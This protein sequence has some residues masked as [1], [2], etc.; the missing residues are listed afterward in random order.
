VNRRE[1]IVALRNREDE[2][3]E[4]LV[5]V[6]ERLTHFR[7]ESPETGP[8]RAQ[9]P[10]GDADE[11]RA[12][13]RHEAQLMREREHLKRELASI[14]I[15]HG[16]PLLAQVT[17]ATPCPASWEDM[18]GDGNVRFCSQCSKHVYDLSMLTQADAEALILQHEGKM[19]ARVFLRVDGTVM[20][21]DCWVGTRRVGIV[22]VCAVA[23]VMALV[24]AAFAYDAAT[25]ELTSKD[26]PCEARYVEGPNGAMVELRGHAAGQSAICVKPPSQKTEHGQVFRTGGAMI[27][28]HY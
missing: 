1:R 13:L 28:P 12:L 18:R 3:R 6:R 24:G 23:S 8:Y 14:G 19:C 26:D 9:A 25:T 27:A 17:I 7:T 2:V 20:T 22:A 16:L 11:H 21:A 10:N 4:Q 15:H 5:V